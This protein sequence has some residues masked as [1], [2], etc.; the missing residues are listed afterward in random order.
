MA[1]AIVGVVCAVGAY[2]LIS[3]SLAA[4]ARGGSAE[5]LTPEGL[6]PL[7]LLGALGLGA[8]VTL[9]LRAKP[10]LLRLR[11]ALAAPARRVPW[12]A[13]LFLVGFGVFLLGEVAG[14]TGPRVVRLDLPPDAKPLPLTAPLDVGGEEGP[15]QGGPVVARLERQQHAVVVEPLV[16]DVTLDGQPLLPDQRH[17][18]PSGAVLEAGE[19]RLRIDLPRIS[20]VLGGAVLGRL[21]G[22]LALVIGLAILAPTLLPR[23]IRR[24]TLRE[25][26]RGALAWL[27]VLPLYAL[28]VVGGSA[29]STA[30]GVPAQ[31]HDLVQVVV[32]EGFA[33][34]GLVALLAAVLAPLKEE[35]LLRGILLPALANVWGP[36]GAL[37][38]SSALFALIHLSLAALVPMFVLG[39][40]FGALRLTAPD[41]DPLTAAITAHVLH[42]G[43]TLA[44]VAL[45]LL[46][47]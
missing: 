15:L 12:T 4:A 46:A 31:S 30:L 27:A 7:L 32:R 28:S 18:V 8:L 37:L 36:R 22:L 3:A 24:P 35:L 13:G 26:G 33:A 34:L 40:L 41:D 2:G 14:V 6:G 42:N 45:R 17:P 11:Q 25:A 23:L 38:A 5:G 16:A 39:L 1:G 47:G 10:G 19:H 21:A 29:L 44:L 20:R 9:A 43:A